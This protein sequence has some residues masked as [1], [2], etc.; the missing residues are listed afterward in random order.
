MVEGASVDKVLLGG[1]GPTA[2]DVID[3]EKLELWILARVLGEDV[4]VAWT[5]EMLG[6]NFLS[7]VAIE[8]SQ[9]PLGH[10]ARAALLDDLVDHRDSRFGEDADRRARRFQSRRHGVS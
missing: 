5:K 9:L 8:E 4:V 3:G 7:G 2:K 10:F 6:G 1:L